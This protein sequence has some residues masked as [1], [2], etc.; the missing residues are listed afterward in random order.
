[1]AKIRAPYLFTET[2]LNLDQ[3]YAGSTI[4]ISLSKSG[5][6]ER[7]L[8][9]DVQIGSDETQFTRDHL[10]SEASLYFRNGEKYHGSFLW[11]LLDDRRALEIQSVDLSQDAG[12]KT[13]AILT[14]LLRFPAAIR[15][16]C[17]AFADSTDRDVLNVFAI[18]TTDELWTL[19]LHREIFIHPKYSESLMSD[20]CKVIKPSMFA[21]T[22]PYRL[23]SSTARELFVSMIDGQVVRLTRRAGE[24]G[25][26]WHDAVYSEGRWGTSFLKW[27]SGPS[28]RFGDLDLDPTAA[29]SL[30]PTSFDDDDAHLI[31]VCLN[32]TLRIWNLKTGRISAELDILGEEDQKYLIAANQRQ[33][34]QLV[35]MPARQEFY[36]V[37]YSPKQHQ[38]KF[39]AIF[40]AEAGR[41]GIRE[42]RPEIE[43][44]PP[45]ETLMDTAVWNLEEFHLRP[46][47]GAKQT[48][49]WIRV[50]SGQASQVF[51][52]SFDP[53]DFGHKLHEVSS[54]YVKECWEQDWVTVFPGRQSLDSLDALSPVNAPDA[55]PDIQV[56]EV[57]DHWLA[58]LFYPGRFT[59][60]LLEAAL[61]TFTSASGRTL[62]ATSK[63]PLKERLT[64]A[65]WTSA[66]KSRSG[67]QQSV[68]HDISSKWQIFYGIVRDLYKRSTDSVSF[69]VDPHD[70]ISWLVAAD[71]VAPIRECSQLEKIE[72]N[73]E[74]VHALPTPRLALY[75]I[76]QADD[77]SRSEAVDTE[78]GLLGGNLFLVTQTL[79]SLLPPSFQHSFKRVI[80]EDLIAEPSKSTADRLHGMQI[81]TSLLEQL[82]EEDNVRFDEV[83][84]EF[85][86]YQ[87]FRTDR[88]LELLKELTEPEKGRHQQEQITRFG[89]KMVVKIAQET[90][91]LNLEV[92]LNLLA[93]VLYL[94]GS[95]EVEELTAAI[96]GLPEDTVDTMEVD[97]ASPGFDAHLL[98]DKIM[99]LLRENILLDFLASNTRRE[100][101][102]PRRKSVGE[103]PVARGG[104]NPVYAST[105]LQ[106]IFIG[107][108]ADVRAPEEDISPAA[109]LTYTTRAWLTKL[110]VNQYENFSAHVFADL[111]KHGDVDLAEQFLPFVPVTGWSSYL[112]GRLYLEKGEINMA[113][114]WFKK[115]A[116]AM[117]KRLASSGFGCF[118]KTSSSTRVFRR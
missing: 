118:T 53:F 47:R 93:T 65:V 61:E 59:L 15:P 77:E 40:D 36:V 115:A 6:H 22:T 58:F 66:A 51:M 26:R 11:R 87:L 73:A 28:V 5:N 9:N 90:V 1:M 49:L 98:F 54:Q 83:V 23:F 7:R 84:T 86:G 31:T 41:Q 44:K 109:M 21:V 103:S 91:G 67:R 101:P 68:D 32:H 38:F 99:S 2:R 12:Q 37:T 19:T 57:S 60:P 111:V 108:W 82:S 56:P 78:D 80:K 102:K 33:L 76:D 113:A 24:D 16:F 50:R 42:M 88:F 116:F 112:R 10:A 55:S 81:E 85:G 30:A 18:T 69:V 8:S 104:P 64:K 20:W 105:L 39:W 114:D 117:G 71:C 106:S 100:R 43:Y 4:D 94:E 62:G 75:D 17:I 14:L 35:E 95:F 63:A 48:E 45:I 89:A 3:A 25:L 92:L 79:R 27:R 34:L 29:I 72:A 110:E 46:S 13:E 74:I 96:K 97:N 70:Q 107:D 52:L